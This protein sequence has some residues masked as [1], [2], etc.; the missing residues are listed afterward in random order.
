[1][2][3]ISI[4]FKK[5]NTNSYCKSNLFSNDVFLQNLENKLNTNSKKNVGMMLLRKEKDQRYND[6][7]NAH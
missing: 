1:M 5:T 2:G 7:N 3:L 6:D 4:T